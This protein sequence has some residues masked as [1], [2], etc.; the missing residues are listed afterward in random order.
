[1]SIFDRIN[2]TENRSG[3]VIGKAEATKENLTNMLIGIM[4]SMGLVNPTSVTSTASKAVTIKK[5][6]DVYVIT[7]NHYD[8]PITFTWTGLLPSDK[9]SEVIAKLIEDKKKISYVN[10][11]K[12]SKGEY[13]QFGVS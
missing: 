6:G 2:I 3:G 4:N 7:L 12:T 9:V 8:P 5:K 13:V 11:L 1:M 10:N